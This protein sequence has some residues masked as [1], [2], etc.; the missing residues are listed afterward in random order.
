MSEKIR[1]AVLFTGQLRA[2]RKYAENLM[3]NFVELNDLDVFCSFQK[4]SSYVKRPIEGSEIKDE[5]DE[6]AFL[7]ELFKD[8]LKV[9]H[10]VS[11]IHPTETNDLENDFLRKLIDF[12]HYEFQISQELFPDKQLV[13]QWFA[14]DQFGRVAIGAQEMKCFCEKNKIKYDYIVR[15]RIDVDV[16]EPIPI[17]NLMNTYPFESEK[18]V[19]IRRWYSSAVKELFVT[20]QASFFDICLN[21]PHTMFLYRPKKFHPNFNAPEF[22]LGQFLRD[23]QYKTYEWRIEY[24]YVDN[25]AENERKIVCRPQGGFICRTPIIITQFASD[26]DEDELD[27]AQKTDPNLHLEFPRIEKAPVYVTPTPPIVLTEAEYTDLFLVLFVVFLVLFVFS[28]GYWWL[29]FRHNQ[30]IHTP[31]SIKI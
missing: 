19:Y 22:Q 20:T 14:A 8:R 28:N 16:T 6:E 4:H 1:G 12:Q 15:F 23:H 26:M 17:V 31:L 5:H 21:F 3:R 10:W 13:N 29:V 9:L 18:D 2:Y 24:A 27:E 25:E 30:T 7:T 11:K